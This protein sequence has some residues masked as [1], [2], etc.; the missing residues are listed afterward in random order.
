MTGNKGSKRKRLERTASI[1]EILQNIMQQKTG[2]RAPAIRQIALWENWDKAVGPSI[3]KQAWPLS[4]RAGTLFVG[5]ANPS[6]LVEL[7]YRKHMLIEKLNQA[8]GREL[9]KDIIIRRAKRD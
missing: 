6:W 8:V 4:F 9:V 5:T 1:G 3:A 2:K 7:Q